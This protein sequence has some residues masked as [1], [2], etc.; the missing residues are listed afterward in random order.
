MEKN[1][2]LLKD[3]IENGI[4]SSLIFNIH[5]TKRNYGTQVAPSYSS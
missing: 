4:A 2:Q 1:V 3:N 5:Q